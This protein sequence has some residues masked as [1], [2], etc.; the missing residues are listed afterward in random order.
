MMLFWTKDGGNGGYTSIENSQFIYMMSGLSVEP[1]RSMSRHFNI[2]KFQMN[3][4]LLIIT[5]FVFCSKYRV[6][7]LKENLVDHKKRCL[8]KMHSNLCLN[9][10]YDSENDPLGK[11]NLIHR[12]QGDPLIWALVRDVRFLNWF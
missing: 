2:V 11:E 7:C 12:G 3:R 1:T 6:S 4:L 10:R 5:L 8:Y 9:E